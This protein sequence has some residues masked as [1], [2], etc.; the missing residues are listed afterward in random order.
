M[1]PYVGAVA[2]VCNAGIY[3]HEGKY[4]EAGLNMASAAATIV[5]G[6]PVAS[7]AS[8][9]LK[10]LGASEKAATKI[11]CRI[12]TAVNAAPHA[13]IAGLSVAQGTQKFNEGKYLEAALCFVTAGA[14]TFRAWNVGTFCFAEG[15]QVVV[16]MEYD[17]DGVFVQY[18]TV[19]IE[20][21]KVGDLVYS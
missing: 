2:D 8:K 5:T 12:G 11:G 7:A 17:P 1:I 10:I 6:L 13:A 16:G 14:S 15:T 20:D 19:N 21:I 4:L 3:Y 9:G 18:V